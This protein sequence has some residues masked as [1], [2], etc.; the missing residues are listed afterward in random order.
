MTEFEQTVMKEFLAIKDAIGEVK[1]KLGEIDVKLDADYH[2][3]HGNGKP[4]LVS[5]HSDLEKRVH[6]LEILNGITAKVVVAICWIITTAI[7]IW[8][9]VK[10]ST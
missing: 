6:K 3:L 7:A 10:S 8:G 5:E 4:G 2:V 1:K 9:V